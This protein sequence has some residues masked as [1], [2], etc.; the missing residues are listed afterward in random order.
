MRVEE[1]VEQLNYGNVCVAVL[2]GT[3]LRLML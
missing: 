3:G 1:D 2:D